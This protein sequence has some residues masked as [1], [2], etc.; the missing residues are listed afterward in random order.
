MCQMHILQNCSMVLNEAGWNQQQY[1]SLQL[2]TALRE[3]EKYQSS[4]TIAKGK[5]KPSLCTC[6][7]L[8]TGDEALHIIKTRLRDDHNL[9]DSWV[10]TSP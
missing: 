4:T 6:P 2:V 3:Q 8:E 9:Q 7:K 5:Q 10:K 1:N